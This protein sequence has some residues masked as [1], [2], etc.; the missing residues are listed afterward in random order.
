[1]VALISSQQGH[2][3]F[4]KIPM[5]FI[6]LTTAQNRYIDGGVTTARIFMFI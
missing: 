3:M 6:I 2:M 5:V 1:M 4:Y